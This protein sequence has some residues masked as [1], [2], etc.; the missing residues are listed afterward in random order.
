MAIVIADSEKSPCIASGFSSFSSLATFQPVSVSV[1][2]SRELLGEMEFLGFFSEGFKVCNF[3]GL[4]SQ[5]LG[6]WGRR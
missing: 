2:V 1:S 6:G 5:P 4:I 3:G